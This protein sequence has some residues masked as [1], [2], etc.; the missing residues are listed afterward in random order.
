MRQA[1]IRFIGSLLFLLYNS[2]LFAAPWYTGPLLAPSGHTIPAGHT[3]LEVYGFFTDNEGIYNRHWKLT[4]APM[5]SSIV[6]NPIFTH[7]ISDSM[8]V[9]FSAPYAYNRFHGQNSHHMSDV[10][11]TLGYQLIEQKGRR[12]I[13]DLRVTIQEIIPTGKFE[14]LDPVNNGTDSTGIGS[15]QTAFNLNFQHLL[16]ITDVHYLRTRLSLA[17]VYAAD[18][19]VYGY[20]SFGGAANT[21]GNVHPGDLQS[22]DIAGELSLTQHLVAV[23]EGFFAHRHRTR[24]SGYAGTNS[25][26]QPAHIGQNPTDEITIAPALEWNFNS[27]VGLIAGVW[28][29]LAG[30][31]TSEFKSYVI[32]INAFW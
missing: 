6:G 29:T 31:D 16:P 30:R 21:L 25:A 10:S 32:A 1:V 2:V 9:Q 15:Y 27:N 17:Y 22:I 24:F 13:P 26:G 7:G 3:N 20:N 5:G 12:L 23:M 19:S 28:K 8:D 14:D 18:V 11:A 4:H